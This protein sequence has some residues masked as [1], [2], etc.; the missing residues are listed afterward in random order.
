LGL[1]FLIVGG[2]FGTLLRFLISGWAHELMGSNFPYGTLIINTTG[3]FFIG[4]LGTTA[5]EGSLISANYR[6]LLVIGFLGAF[7]TF[8]TFAYESWLLLKDGQ[9]VKMWCN[10]GGSLVFGLIAVVLGVFFA[11]SL[12]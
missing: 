11:R 10:L 2:A 6:L 8:S 1:I 4:F 5:D 3:C 7:T 12:L 9:V